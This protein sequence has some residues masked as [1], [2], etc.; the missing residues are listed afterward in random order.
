MCAVCPLWEADR[1]LQGLFW[2]G[3]PIRPRITIKVKVIVL[4]NILSS[5][6]STLAVFFAVGILDIGVFTPGKGLYFRA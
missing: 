2:L 3:A 5:D 1:P 6:S 4:P